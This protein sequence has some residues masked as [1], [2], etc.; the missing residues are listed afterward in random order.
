MAVDQLCPKVGIAAYHSLA[1]A[2][3]YPVNAVLSYVEKVPHSR[4]PSVNSL[5]VSLYKS[6]QNRIFECSNSMQ[7]EILTSVLNN[8]EEKNE[9]HMSEHLRCNCILCSYRNVQNNFLLP[10]TES[11]KTEHEDLTT[12]RRNSFSVCFFLSLELIKVHSADYCFA[13]IFICTFFD[14]GDAHYFCHILL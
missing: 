11:K 4:I 3:W 2:T 12:W 8:S 10:R 5:D 13:H 7:W 14:C 1:N 6:Y 9:N